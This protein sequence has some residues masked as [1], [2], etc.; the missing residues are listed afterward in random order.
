MKFLYL[1]WRNLIRKKI[2]AALTLMCIVV[3]FLLFGYLAAISQ[4]FS[5]GVDVA[6]MDRLVVRHKVSLIRLLPVSYQERM[7]AIP[8]VEAAAHA[9]WFGGVYQDPKNFFAQ[10]PVEPEKHLD[11]F[12]EFLLPQD[13]KDRQRSLG[14]HH[15]QVWH[16]PALQAV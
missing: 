7:E 11:M 4:A 8:G 15:I 3:A 6:G 14:I 10:M 1:V 2:R 16:R 13:Q 9:T 5:M 12:P